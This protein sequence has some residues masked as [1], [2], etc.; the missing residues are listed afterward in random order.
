MQ[1]TLAKMPNSENMEPE[2][3]ICRS[4]TGAPLEG[5]EKRPTYKT[6]DLKLF[7]SKTN[8][9]TKMKEKLKEWLTSPF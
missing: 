1:V 5:W 6:F 4:Q 2:D 8:A 7:L 9:G 3:T